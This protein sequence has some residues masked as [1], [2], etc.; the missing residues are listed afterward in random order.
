MKL[1]GTR[2]FPLLIAA[3]SLYGIAASGAPQA[4]A[5]NSTT[6][7][8]PGLSKAIAAILADPAVSRAHWGI[9]VVAADGRPI[10]SLNAG[11]FFEP[12]SNAKLF[13]TATAFAVFSVESRFQTNVFALGALDA[14]GTLHGEIVI[15]GGGDPSISGRA[16][17][18]AG[19]TERPNPPL[20]ALE[21]LADQIAKGGLVRKVSGGVTGDDTLFPFERYGAGWGWDDLQWEFGAPVSALTVNDNVVYLDLMPGAKL[22]DPISA[23][24][25]P[26]VP[27]YTLENSAVTGAVSPKTKI[28]IDRQPGSKTVRLYGALPVNS[29]GA[30]I[31]LAIEDPAEFAAIAFREMLA[32]RG[33]TVSG[34]ASAQHRLPVST[35]DYLVASRTPLPSPLA[36]GQPLAART[37]QQ[38]GEKLLASHTSPPLGQDLTAILARQQ[39][40][41]FMRSCFSATWARR[42]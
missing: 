23:T 15:E 9:S 38:P 18:Y 6:N 34:A 8:N 37:S 20:Q 33:I 7:G 26:P 32:D 24:W 42:C 17:P 31:A 1:R 5:Q 29:K 35:E 28:G 27:Y 19:K 16:W 13:T 14:D 10:Y 21:D 11:Q 25:N 30:H 2:L 40:R 36:T 12:A 4:A 41:T 22:G 39:P 3:L